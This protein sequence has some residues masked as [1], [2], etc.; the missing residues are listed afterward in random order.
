MRVRLDGVETISLQTIDD[1]MKWWKSP[2]YK[3]SEIV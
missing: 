1:I 2:V 3:K